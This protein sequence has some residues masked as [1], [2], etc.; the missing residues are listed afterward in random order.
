ML[1]LHLAHS[2]LVLHDRHLLDALVDPKRYRYSGPPWLLR[3]IWWFVPKPD[4]VILL[5]APPEVLQSRKQEVPL[6]ESERQ[7][8][9]YRS[10]VRPMS[11]GRIVDAA[12]PLPQV[13]NEV[14]DLVL[15]HLA[16]RTARRLGF[17]PVGCDAR[18]AALSE[19]GPRASPA[20]TGD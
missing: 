15:L 18:N 13:V 17:E 2:T 11:N 12:R 10:L 5:D 19:D 6:Q 7:R 3:L 1:R 14:Q 16:S 20:A 8:E 9:A 4:L